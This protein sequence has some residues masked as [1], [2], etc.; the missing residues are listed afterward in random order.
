MVIYCM[1]EKRKR[2]G[3]GSSKRRFDFD[4]RIFVFF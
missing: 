3:F 2:N 4:L 1:R